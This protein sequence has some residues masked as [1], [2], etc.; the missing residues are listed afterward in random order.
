MMLRSNRKRLKSYET[1]SRDVNIRNTYISN[2][3]MYVRRADH[4]LF[5]RGGPVIESCREKR[6]PSFLLNV[7]SGPVLRRRGCCC[8]VACPRYTLD[9]T[10]TFIFHLSELK[11]N[12]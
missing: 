11:P 5:I 6:P 10:A 2:M 1:E 12:T 3:C 8:L 4:V 7:K 9:M